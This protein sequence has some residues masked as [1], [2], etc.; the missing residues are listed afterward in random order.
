MGSFTDSLFSSSGILFVSSHSFSLIS[1]ARDFLIFLKEPAFYFTAF[2]LL[3][4]CFSILLISILIIIIFVLLLWISLALLFLKVEEAGVIDW[5][6]FIFSH[7][8]VYRCNFPPSTTL[9]ESHTF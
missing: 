9:A 2:S 6:L 7:I 3:F 4:F 5:K 8:D 1:L